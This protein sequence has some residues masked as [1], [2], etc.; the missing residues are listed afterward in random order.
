[1][2]SNRND[3]Y[4]NM[5]QALSRFESRF[6]MPDNLIADTMAEIISRKERRAYIRGLIVAS[7]AVVL[8]I[9]CAAILLIYLS[10]V[11]P[12]PLLSSGI[13]FGTTMTEANSV[14]GTIFSNHLILMIAGSAA[15]FLPLDH[16]M[17]S[18]FA[19]RR[20]SETLKA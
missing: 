13:A 17:R 12:E 1:M 4:L 3:F 11:S 18:R 15:V 20:R 9:A 2:E 16:L 7:V 5:R 6:E 8:M 19:L 10:S 14:I